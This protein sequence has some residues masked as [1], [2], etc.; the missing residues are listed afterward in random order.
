M[1]SNI[2]PKFEFLLEAKNAHSRKS[3]PSAGLYQ[4]FATITHLNVGIGNYAHVRFFTIPNDIKVRLNQEYNKLK[5]EHYLRH[6]C[7]SP[8]TF[9]KVSPMPLICRLFLKT[10]TF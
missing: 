9:G 6:N 8:Q 3:I 7:F 2:I 10:C 4:I 5:Q 1:I